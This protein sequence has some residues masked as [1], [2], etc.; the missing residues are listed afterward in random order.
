MIG[1]LACV[2]T[3]CLITIEEGSVGGFGSHRAA[4]ISSDNRRC[5]IASLPRALHGAAGRTIID[6]D[7]PEKMYERAGLSAPGIV[8]DRSRRAG[9]PA[10]GHCQHPCVNGALGAL[11]ALGSGLLTAKYGSSPGMTSENDCVRHSG[12]AR[13][14]LEREPEP[15][16]KCA[17]S[18]A[19]ILS[20]EVHALHAEIPAQA[21]ARSCGGPA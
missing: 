3:R 12:Q 14:E 21:H 17:R 16:L 15:S 20:Y 6:H 9:P 4:C 5:S 18:A 13:A 8:W 7:K 1:R 19:D 11:S 2:S 10:A